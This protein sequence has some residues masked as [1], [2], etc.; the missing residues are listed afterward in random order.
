MTQ[1][2]RHLQG[3]RHC[4][5]TNSIGKA[6]ISKGFGTLGALEN[7]TLIKAENFAGEPQEELYE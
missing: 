7:L 5:M 3:E 1:T 2:P 4:L 6:N